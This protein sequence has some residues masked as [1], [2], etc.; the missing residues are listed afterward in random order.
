MPDYDD[1]SSV[2]SKDN[3]IKNT[4]RYLQE[5]QKKQIVD[6]K[7]E[8]EIAASIYKKKRLRRNAV[9]RI[10]TKKAET[11]L[12]HKISAPKSKT[13]EHLFEPG[14][15]PQNFNTSRSPKQ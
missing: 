14:H 1:A 2:N 10:L 3:E 9:Q 11:P 15:F 12:A 7:L 6:L 8:R 13:F 4:N 5:W